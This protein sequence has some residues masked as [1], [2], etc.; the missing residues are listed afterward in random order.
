M[1]DPPPDD[2]PARCWTLEAALQILPDVR[3]HTQRA[4][5]LYAPLR[6][7]RDGSPA[8]TQKRADAEQGMRQCLSQ[9]V[10]EMEALGVSVRG[11]W[12]VEFPSEGGAFP[13]HWPEQSL[14]S[15]RPSG[16]EDDDAVVSI[17]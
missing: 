16:G 12:R 2:P 5:S 14:R 4:R 17:H 6:E 15:W 3:R 1:G 13:W 10:R 9:W 11:L 7:K 8:G